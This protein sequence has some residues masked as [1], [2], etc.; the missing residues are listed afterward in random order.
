[1][2]RWLIWLI[3]V[4]VVLLIATVWVQHITFHVH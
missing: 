4:L 3:A 2:P 1:M